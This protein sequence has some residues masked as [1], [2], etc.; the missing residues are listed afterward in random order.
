MNFYELKDEIN[1]PKYNGLTN[2]EIATLLNTENI[3]V[4]VDVSSIQLLYWAA[5]NGRFDKIKVA[6][7]TH[8]IQ[9]IRAIAQA[10]LKLID[11][12]DVGYSRSS[13]KG[14]LDNFVLSGVLTSEDAEALD[15]M[16]D[17][18]MSRASQ[19]KYEQITED[20]I[21]YAKSL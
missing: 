3:P 15:T 1:K 6:S 11:R 13:H 5:F 16:C 4:V 18:M 8:P 14:L 19:L 20:H 21:N 7:E 2:E 12:I 9:E 17:K 10:A